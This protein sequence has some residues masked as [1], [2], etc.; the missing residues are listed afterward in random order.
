MKTLSGFTAPFILSVW[1]LL[2][3]CYLF[4]PELRSTASFSTEESQSIHYFQSIS[5]SFGQV[6]FQEH[7]LSGLFFLAGIGIHSHIA[8]CYAFI[9]A[10]LALP[11]IL[12]PG[13]DA[14][15]LNKGLLG[16]NAVLCAIALGSTNLKSLVWVCLAVFL[17]IILQLIGI[18]QGFTTLTAPFVVAVWITILIKI[19]ITKRHSHDTER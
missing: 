17:S 4:A 7:L 19:F 15:L 1:L 2:G 10:L 16:Y 14:A 13:I 9:G 11:A 8:A 6:M 3:F 18:H 5:L 12:L